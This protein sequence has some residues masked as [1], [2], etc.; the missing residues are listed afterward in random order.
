MRRLATTCVFLLGAL[1]AV[2]A[3]ALPTSLTL[4]QP[5]PATAAVAI[6]LAT[7]Q[8][9]GYWDDNR[10]RPGQTISLVE[11][12]LFLEAA[13]DLRQ[14]VRVAMR[15]PL[16]H[17]TI[18]QLADGS[19]DATGFGIGDAELALAWQ[20]DPGRNHLRGGLEL[21]WKTPSG[22]A[23]M[24][25]AEIDRGEPALAPLG[26]GGHDVDLWGGGNWT[27]RRFMAGAA[28]GYRVRTTTSG[29]WIWNGVVL[30]GDVPHDRLMLAAAGSVPLPAGLAVDLRLEAFHEIV[31]EPS[32]SAQNSVHAGSGGIDLRLDHGPW[33]TVLGVNGP[34]WGRLYPARPPFAFAEREP[35]L[36]VRSSATIERR[37]GQGVW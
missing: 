24:S 22:R 25:L 20:S 15:L 5:E 27:Y 14:G 12:T 26:T 23:D 18:D 7:H 11:R 9:D 2:P 8:G 34:L 37:F 33:R 31:R 32:L 10:R 21:R 19:L 17:R 1:H 13:S 3:A 36:G 29:L 4:L 30:P 16:V 35:L 6:G 28:L